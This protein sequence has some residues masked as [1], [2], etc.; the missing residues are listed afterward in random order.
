MRAEH[1]GLAWSVRVAVGTCPGQNRWNTLGGRK[2]AVFHGVK[3]CLILRSVHATP[4]GCGGWR[5]DEE[6]GELTPRERRSP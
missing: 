5:G 2:G 3:E 6:N 1:V 4:P